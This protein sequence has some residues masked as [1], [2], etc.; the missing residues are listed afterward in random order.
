MV[1][2]EIVMPIPGRDN[3]DKYADSY[4]ERAVVQRLSAEKLASL[5]PLK[6]Y[7]RALD[8]GCGT[9]FAIE[10]LLNRGLNIER[11]LGVDKSQ[12][13]IDV[14]RSK[15]PLMEFEVVDF[16]SISNRFAEFDLLV[17][18]FA[19]QWLD[20][21]LEFILRAAKNLRPGA[22][23]CFS[24]PIEGTFKEILETSTIYNDRPIEIMK[25]LSYDELRR[26][27]RGLYQY[28]ERASM[29]QTFP[30]LMDAM[31]SIKKAGATYRNRRPY[32]Y[33]EM[34]NLFIA[35]GELPFNEKGATL[36]Y[37]VAFF[38]LGL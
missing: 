16:A 13:M 21:P 5:V 15:F 36:T 37:E 12:R 31:L 9:G 23:F 4:D 32:S 11:C 22:A 34:K 35:H 27:L 24:I 6:K 19:L 38:V 18:N 28:S 10:A 20:S 33:K 14:C 7:A 25:L 3:F 2:T 29:R 30:S 17:S 26:S 1:C 8:L